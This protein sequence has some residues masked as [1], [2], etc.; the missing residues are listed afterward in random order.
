MATFCVVVSLQDPSTK[1]PKPG[2][3]IV[4]SYHGE[5][6][7]AVTHIEG[8]KMDT[9]FMLK[10][11]KVTTRQF[12]TTKKDKWCAVTDAELEDCLKDGTI[13]GTISYGRQVYISKDIISNGHEPGADSEQ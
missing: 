11:G 1:M 12:S 3:T 4:I 10:N 8:T 9:K 6:L 7:A 2:D 5:K 13:H